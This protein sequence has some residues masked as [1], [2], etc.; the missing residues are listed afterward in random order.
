MSDKTPSIQTS[1]NNNDAG[2]GVGT[3]TSLEA[4]Y[5]ATIL[6][7][8]NYPI[9][10]TNID[11][12]VTT[13]NAAAERTLGYQ[14]SE[15]INRHTPA[16]W[17]DAAE[18]ATRSAV[19]SKELGQEIA[20]GFRAFVAKAELTGVADENE[21]TL[22]RKD[23]S[24]LPATL[25][26]TCL[27]DSAGKVIG[28]LGVL[29][30]LTAEKQAQAILSEREERLQKLAAHVPGV[31]YQFLLRPD[32]T[33][34]FPYASEG[35]RDLFRVSPQDVLHDAAPLLALGHPDDLELILKS[36]AHSAQTLTRWNLDYRI[37]FPDGTVRWVQGQAAP[38]RLPDG[39]TLWHGFMSDIT[40]RKAAEMELER[41]KL[42][43][44]GLSDP[45]YLLSP[46][47]H[48]RFYYG[49]H[50][51]LRHYGLSESELLS[52]TVTDLD[53]S[54]TVAALNSMWARVRNGERLTIE[55]V[56]NHP[57]RGPIPVELTASYLKLASGDYVGGVIQDISER[58]RM[59]GQVR[60]AA[61]DRLR[62]EKEL[63]ESARL[64][65]L[66]VLAGGIAH[67]FNNLLTGVI[68]NASL[69]HYELPP[70]SPALATV[71]QI[72][73]AAEQAAK[74]CAQMLAYSGKGRFLIKGIDINSMISETVT[75]LGIAASKNCQLQYEMARG[76][77]QVEA[78]ETQLRQVV[79]NLV[80]NASEAIGNVP[81]II[82]VK[83]S[84]A[85]LG[86]SSPEILQHE[87]QLAPGT[88]VRIEVRDTGPGMSEDI[89]KKI[90]DPFFTT[91]FT[92][93]G[94]GL[95]AVQGIVRGHK[96]L[97]TLVSAP[98][99]GSSFR[100]WLPA[101]SNAASASEAPVA[102][103]GANWRG[104]GHI[105][106]V[107]D[108]HVIRD[109]ASR[110]L[111]LA[112]FTTSLAVNGAEAIELLSA[113]PAAYS[114]ILLDMTMPVMD[115]VEAFSQLRQ[116]NPSVP[117]VIMSG[118]TKHGIDAPFADNAP[119]AFIDKPL[120]G[121]VLIDTLRKI[122]TPP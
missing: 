37:R 69:L 54:T 62:M 1:D 74:L 81:G 30:D 66:G 90:F 65:S 59:E 122:L 97:I 23:G 51:L 18:V 58:K 12:V 84:L 2:M 29:K 27:R 100:I 35:I 92:G 56:H 25:S 87:E 49:N 98:G 11:G 8:P 91:K 118:F 33:R 31:L 117:I 120:N 89:Q 94:L 85:E 9:I 78:D 43:L 75:L 40:D 108:E 114:M 82:T 88:Y 34:C 110:L 102:A 111:Q 13:F 24:R 109:V 106:V 36:I 10:S 113:N 50:A 46:T 20:P 22:I 68:G 67:D 21:W 32:G 44:Q 79:M 76:L 6:A 42:L 99:K 28:Y 107:D 115:G 121:P 77:P 80:L 70:D 63:A 72:E 101:A 19:L 95:S 103:V 53:N 14:A 15:I 39:S 4:L 116:L 64:E 61:D 60:A 26:A 57:V 73:Q 38:E 5:Y 7:S 52:S 83:T 55:T 17:H 86:R 3:Q 104:S 45:V 47:E 48:F 41:F 16:I 105:L 93:R 71:M 112:G 96:G 119:T